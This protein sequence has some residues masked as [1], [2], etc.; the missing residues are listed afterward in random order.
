MSEAACIGII[1]A[2]TTIDEVNKKKWKKYWMKER[3]KKTC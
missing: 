2:L 3:L 1:F